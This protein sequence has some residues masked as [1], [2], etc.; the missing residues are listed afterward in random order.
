MSEVKARKGFDVRVTIV[1]PRTGKVVKHQ[2][3]ELLIVKNG[4]GSTSQ[5]FKRDGKWFNPDGSEVVAPVK[6]SDLTE[7]EI[8]ADLERQIE[9][10]QKRLSLLRGAPKDPD[11]GRTSDSVEHEGN[12]K[13]EDPQIMTA[14]LE[15]IVAADPVIKAPLSKVPKIKKKVNEAASAKMKTILSGGAESQASTG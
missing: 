14:D 7:S 13:A 3:Y 8:K 9:A 1:D 10:M 5:F 12:S 11:L 6:S 4:P 15:P 2:P